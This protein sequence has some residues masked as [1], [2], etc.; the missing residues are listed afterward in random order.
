MRQTTKD[1]M[2]TLAIDVV[3]IPLMGIG[4]MACVSLVFVIM[5]STAINWAAMILL[6]YAYS[7][8]I[9][10]GLLFDCDHIVV[11]EWIFLLFFWFLVL[12][13][14]RKDLCEA[15]VKCKMSSYFQTW[16]TLRQTDPLC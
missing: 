8:S 10:F 1:V 2:V 5:D 15:R 12:V 14:Q 3:L 4:N 11:M 13:F 9:C 7:V 6:M 16:C